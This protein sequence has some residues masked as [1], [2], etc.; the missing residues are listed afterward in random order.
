MSIIDLFNKYNK[1]ISSVIRMIMLILYGLFFAFFTLDCTKAS[2]LDNFEIYRT[3]TL[4]VILLLGLIR[5]LALVNVG[6]EYLSG[7]KLKG[8]IAVCCKMAL[9]F[10]ALYYISKAEF[11]LGSIFLFTVAVSGVREYRLLKAAFYIGVGFIVVFFVL[12]ML[13]IVENQR[14]DAFGFSYRTHYASFILCVT[15]AYS[16]IKNGWFTWL[17]ELGL[18]CLDLYILWISAKTVFLC[19]VLLTFIVMWRHYR[20]GGCIPYQDKEAYGLISY[21]FLVLYL[22]IVAVN[23][24][25]EKIKIVK[26]KGILIKL[27]KY[28]F[29]LCCAFNLFMVLTYRSL[30]KYWQ[31]LPGLSTFR[32]RVILSLLGFDEFPVTLFGNSIAQVGNSISETYPHF[33]FV[34]DSAYVRFVLQYGLVPFVCMMAILTWGLIRLYKSGRFFAM[35]AVSIFAVDSIMNYHMRNLC[36]NAFIIYAFCTIVNCSKGMDECAKLSF[37]KISRGK[38]WL[39]ALGVACVVLIAGAWCVTAYQIS[40][41][42]GRTPVCKA[43]VVV[44]G[45]YVEGKDNLLSAAFLYL[46][47]YDDSVCIVNSEEDKVLLTEYGIDED[48]VWVTE[49]SDIDEMLVS[50]HDLIRENDLPERITVCAYDVQMARITRH[51]EELHIPVNSL[52]FRPQDGYIRMFAS[53]QWRLLCEGII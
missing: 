53:E 21:V 24:V 19:L 28:S 42:R 45:D 41:W 7:D 51:S 17:G 31:N 43:T 3:I 15:L 33:Y 27:M 44:P 34:F 49:S 29:L 47:C 12:S 9:I 46:N 8:L 2:F 37:T 14:G 52:T 50:A 23:W 32:S 25:A 18:I 1:K 4:V 48:R 11:A 22:P 39:L 40:S 26:L 35:F 38:R 30:G 13:G 6:V 20:R 36:F 16:I 5:I 10:L